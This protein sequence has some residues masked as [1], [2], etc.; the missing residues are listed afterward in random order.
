MELE[1]RVVIASQWRQKGRM[2]REIPLEVVQM[3]KH[4]GQ[5]WEYVCIKCWNVYV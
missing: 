2:P 1:R 4:N 3:R 5:D